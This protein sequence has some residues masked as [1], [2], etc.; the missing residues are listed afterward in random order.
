MSWSWVRRQ[1]LARKHPKFDFT[2]GV[3]QWDLRR[4]KILI[5]NYLESPFQIFFK[6]LLMFSFLVKYIICFCATF[7]PETNCLRY[8]FSL[9]KLSFVS[10]L[11][12][13]KQKP[14]RQK[15]ANGRDAWINLVRAPQSKVCLYEYV[16]KKFFRS[17][18]VNTFVMLFYSLL[19]R[20]FTHLSKHRCSRPQS[21]YYWTST[22]Y[23]RVF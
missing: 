11:L 14:L 2:R 15:V 5:K 8:F 22:A 3:R 10:S 17:K 9:E 12:T 7:Y 13:R 16:S 18:H 19:A 21:C 4:S 23:A 1:A 20:N 6:K